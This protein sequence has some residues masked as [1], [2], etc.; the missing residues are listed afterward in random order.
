MGV[1]KGLTHKGYDVEVW[2]YCVALT[3]EVVA[4]ERNKGLAAAA[5]SGVSKLLVD[6]CFESNLR[7][8]SNNVIITDYFAKQRRMSMTWAMNEHWNLS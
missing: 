6:C 8:V 7:I 1:H 3:D 4:W 5:W 2:W